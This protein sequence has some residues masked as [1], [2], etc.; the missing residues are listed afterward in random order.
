MRI[1]QKT[2]PNEKNQKVFILLTSHKKQKI[3][4]NTGGEKYVVRNI[5][6]TLLLVTV[7]FQRDTLKAPRNFMPLNRCYSTNLLM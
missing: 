6:K 5:F 7:G 3:K 1:S 2:I 4:E